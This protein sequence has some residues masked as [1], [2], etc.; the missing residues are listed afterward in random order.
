M[1]T[2]G[3]YGGNVWTAWITLNNTSSATTATTWTAA[4]ADQTW[5]GWVQ[6]ANV[7]IG[8]QRYE[9][10]YQPPRETEA[11][12]AARLARE[13][14]YRREAAERRAQRA[15]ADTRAEGMLRALLNA[16][17]IAMLD[18]EDKFR[19]TC[20]SG[21]VYEI[22]RGRQ[23]NVFMLGEDGRTRVQELC[24]HVAPNI[25]NADN[26]IAQFLLLFA[27]ETAYRKVANI[28]DIRDRRTHRTLSSSGREAP[29]QREHLRLVA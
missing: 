4:T 1:A 10:S 14:Q 25:P 21:R 24:A 22:C 7:T 26:M 19:M 6:H 2:G 17:Q 27:D 16:E 3:T 20:P 15:V 8:N 5:A 28:W 12:R 29:V 23:H 13:E 18:A 9:A 11:Q